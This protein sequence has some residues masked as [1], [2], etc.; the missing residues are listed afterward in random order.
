MC[1][2]VFDYY[3]PVS[4]VRN[5]KENNWNYWKKGYELDRYEIYKIGNREY[6]MIF[7]VKYS[8]VKIY[9]KKMEDLMHHLEYIKNNIYV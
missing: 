4:Y 6:K 5:H 3:F 2:N 8:S 9:Y 1:S 7:P